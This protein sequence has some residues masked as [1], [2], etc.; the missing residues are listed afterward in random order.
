[1]AQCWLAVQHLALSAKLYTKKVQ[2][3]SVHYI[4][5]WFYRSPEVILGHP[6]NMAI[7]MWSLGCIMAEL[8]MGCPLFAGE[9]E[10]EQLACIMELSGTLML[11]WA[12]FIQTDSRRQT[13]FDSKGFPKNITNSWEKKR[14][15]GSKDL[16]LVLKTCDSS[17]LDFLRRCLV[18]EPLLR[19]TP[20]QALKHAWI[21]DARNLKPQPRPQNLRKSSFCF[22]SKPRKNKVQGHH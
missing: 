7:D 22:P 5:T 3:E 1:M 6:Y 13:F 8:Y 19:M 2:V 17:F 20:D 14:Y 12:L 10:V 15:P 4:Q 11:A 21:H 9:N 18:W 16:L